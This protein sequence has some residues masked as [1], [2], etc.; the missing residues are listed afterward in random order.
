MRKESMEIPKTWRMASP[1]KRGEQDDRH[2]QVSGEIG[3]VPGRRRLVTG[4][5]NKDRND[6]HRVN[7]GKQTDK[8]FEIRWKIKERLDHVLLRLCTCPG[9]TTLS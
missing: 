5:T 6:T 1:E 2:R 9:L 4:H 7:Q 3:F 8:K